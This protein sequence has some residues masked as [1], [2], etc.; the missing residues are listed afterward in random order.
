MIV[1]F[2]LLGLIAVVSTV[3]AALPLRSARLRC[4]LLTVHVAV[5]VAVMAELNGP[6]QLEAMV[7]GPGLL[8]AVVRLLIMAYRALGLPVPRPSGD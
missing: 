2:L 5:S 6:W 3:V 7:F 8:V 1:L 4:A